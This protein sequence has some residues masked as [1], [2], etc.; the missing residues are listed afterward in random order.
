MTV[1]GRIEMTAAEIA[2][3]TGGTLE[4]STEV[5]FQRVA[6]LLHAGASEVAWFG[7]AP[8]A[9]GRAPSPKLLEALRDS[10]AGLFLLDADADADSGGRPCVRVERPA[11]AAALLARAFEGPPRA[12]PAGVHPLAVVEDGAQVDASA[13]VGPGCVVR[14]GARIGA[15]VVLTAN[16][17]VGEDSVI[18]DACRLEAGV[19][20]YERVTLGPACTIHAASVLGAPGF[21]YV[22][23][24]GRHV[25]VPQTG[26][27][28]IGA[29]VEIGAATTIDAG[30]FDP[31]EIGDGCIL[32]NQVVIGHNCRLGRA[33][34][35]CAQAGLAGSTEVGDGAIFGGRAGTVGQL[36]IGAGA[37]LAGNAVAGGD[38]EPGAKVA[39]YPAVDHREHLR[40][41]VVLRRLARERRRD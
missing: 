9:G 18:G 15:G 25:P 5:V 30:T 29:G 33:V 19:V 34:V 10:G 27:V 3:Q 12:Y 36:T 39:G 32:D 21:G 11:L 38:I 7:A 8:D 6:S 14:A 16:V 35:V 31:T 24:G 20:L 28:L 22:W 2:A 41:Q 37:I 26:G 4:G 17:Q 40:S 13:S 23:D 1:M